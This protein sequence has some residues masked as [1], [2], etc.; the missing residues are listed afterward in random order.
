[1][2]DVVNAVAQRFKQI[3]NLWRNVCPRDRFPILVA[4]LEAVNRSL[5]RSK[6]RKR[7]QDFFANYTAMSLPA[8]CRYHVHLRCVFRSFS[9]MPA[10]AR[11]IGW[12]A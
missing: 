10:H 11:R 2:R 6:P 9:Q 4:W 5:A 7:R 12:S 3:E 8:A 1:M